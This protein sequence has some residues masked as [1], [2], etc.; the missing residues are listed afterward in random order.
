[1]WRIHEDEKEP[2]GGKCSALA[3]EGS[4]VGNSEISEYGNAF[5]NFVATSE[6]TLHFHLKKIKNFFS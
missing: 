5:K 1:L 6:T 4:W 2:I 3:T